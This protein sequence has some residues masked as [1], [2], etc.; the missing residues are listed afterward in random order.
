MSAAE[1][2]A[3]VAKAGVSPS[4][5]LAQGRVPG[6]RRPAG[7]DPLRTFRRAPGFATRISGWFVPG[8]GLKV[9]SVTAPTHDIGPEPQTGCVDSNRNKDFWD[10][11][12]VNC[13]WVIEDTI[14][15]P[16]WNPFTSGIVTLPNPLTSQATI[17]LKLKVY[18]NGQKQ[19]VRTWEEVDVD[20]RT[21]YSHLG[22]P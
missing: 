12:K 13:S 18:P 16:V 9:D 7:I 11:L 20:G 2:V 4:Q 5:P 17:T 22:N 10:R 14:P 21:Q 8:G 6:D 1:S 19:K 3:M 15:L